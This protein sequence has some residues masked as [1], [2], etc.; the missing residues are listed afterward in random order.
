MKQRPEIV[1]I[2]FDLNLQCCAHNEAALIRVFVTVD[3]LFLFEFAPKIRS[4]LQTNGRFD[5]R[6]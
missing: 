1:L 2:E 5:F 6:T 4:L 3:V